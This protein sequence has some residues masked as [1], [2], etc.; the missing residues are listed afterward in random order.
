MFHL[1]QEAQN[2]EIHLLVLA[3]YVNNRLPMQS[4][5]NGMNITGL[6]PLTILV[7]LWF[8]GTPLRLV[9]LYRPLNILFIYFVVL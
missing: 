6:R 8:F 3:R 7:E 2:A 1:N 4:L 5:L 9:A